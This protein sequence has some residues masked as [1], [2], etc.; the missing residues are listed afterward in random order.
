MTWA[1]Y[2]ADAARD[3]GT[4]CRKGRLSRPSAT[5]GEDVVVV[6]CEDYEMPAAAGDEDVEK[7]AFC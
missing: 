4:C 2:A 7:D 3:P 1:S 5:V 6:A